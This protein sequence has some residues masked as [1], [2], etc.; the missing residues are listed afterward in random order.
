MLRVKVGGRVGADT[1]A[2]KRAEAALASMSAEFGDWLETE[3]DELDQARNAARAEGLAS[4]AGEALYRRAHDLKGQGATYGY[5]IV[6]RLAGL[7]A[8]LL[9]SEAGRSDA[10][11]P[12]VDAHVN[13]IR[14]AVRDGVKDDAHPVGQALVAELDSRVRAISEAA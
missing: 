7:L 3:L 13:A 8:L 4:P 12:L 10:S 2:I 1:D 14:A 5:P 9:E 6:S 11:M